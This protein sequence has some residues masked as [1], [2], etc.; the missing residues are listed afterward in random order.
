MDEI[1]RR[2][3]IDHVEDLMLEGIDDG[4]DSDESNDDEDGN[5]DDNVSDNGE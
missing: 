1:D 2:E 4:D 5:E 3:R